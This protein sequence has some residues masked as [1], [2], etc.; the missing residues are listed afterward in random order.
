ML[1]DRA[2]AADGLE[3]LF[4]LRGGSQGLDAAI[5]GNDDVAIGIGSL[6]CCCSWYMSTTPLTRSHEHCTTAADPNHEHCTTAADGAATTA[7]VIVGFPGETEAQFENS[8]RLMETVYAK[9]A[10]LLPRRALYLQKRT[11]LHR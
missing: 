1:L 5:T 6:I 7:D 10:L 2:P 9:R 4:G 8:L 3:D 11:Y